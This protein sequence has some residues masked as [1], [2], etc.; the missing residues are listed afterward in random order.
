MIG[1]VMGYERMER[2]GTWDWFEVGGERDRGLDHI[3]RMMRHRLRSVG[4][5]E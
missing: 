5:E 1:P 4:E 3:G 2:N